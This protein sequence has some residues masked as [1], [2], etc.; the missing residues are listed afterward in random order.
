MIICWFVVGHV[1]YSLKYELLCQSEAAI[2]E[3]RW[4]MKYAADDLSLSERYKSRIWGITLK[5]TYGLPLLSIPRSVVN[6]N[7]SAGYCLFELMTPEAEALPSANQPEPDIV[8]ASTSPVI[9]AA[10]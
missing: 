1:A 10:Q 8:V 5:L 9:A 2:T 4:I 7:V 6:A 3:S